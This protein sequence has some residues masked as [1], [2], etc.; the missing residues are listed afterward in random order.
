VAITVGFLLMRTVIILL[1]AIFYIGRI[2]TPFLAN[3]VDKFD[4]MSNAAYLNKAPVY[5]RKDLLLHEA[6]RHPYIERLGALFLLKLNCGDRFGTRGGSA[7]RLLFVLTLMPWLK[8]YR[9]SVRQVDHSTMNDFGSSLTSN[10][11][12]T[13]GYSST[14]ENDISEEP[15]FKKCSDDD[16]VGAS[17]RS[18]RSDHRKKKTFIMKGPSMAGYG[19]PDFTA[20]P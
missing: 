15:T 18:E 7:W 9:A 11:T 20:K 14:V 8:K 10:R 16:E 1:L 19:S 3:E 6:H 17:G 13:L 5:Y 4:F 12:K 2:D